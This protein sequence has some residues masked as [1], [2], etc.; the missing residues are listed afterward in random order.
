MGTTYTIA[1]KATRICRCCCKRMFTP[2]LPELLESL[3]VRGAATHSVKILRNKRMVVIRQSKPIHVD[4]PFVASISPQCEADAAIDGT[5]VGL[6]QAKQ[7]AHDDIRAWNGT[8]PGSM[9]R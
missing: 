9:E 6:H 5:S 2:G 3:I 8:N 1:S 7:F 4:G